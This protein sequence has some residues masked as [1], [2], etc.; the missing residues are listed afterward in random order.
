MQASEVAACHWVPLA[1]LLDPAARSRQPV[2]VSTRLAR[3]HHPALRFLLRHSLGPMLFDAVRLEPIE[4]VY[5]EDRVPLPLLWGLTHAVL[6]DFLA[7][8]P[9]FDA[10][11]AY[12]PP[13]LA[14]PDVRVLAWLF[15]PQP[16]G[17]AAGRQMVLR[18]YVSE[19][20]EAYWPRFRWAL[21]TALAA[22]GLVGLAV[23]WHLL[24]TLR[25]HVR[26]R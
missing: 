4:S 21:R 17:P 13:S 22:R 9:P 25:R 23:L 26:R 1:N 2:D 15:A 19:Y 12:R 10:F 20:L 16:P 24:R 18:N 3:T 7:L 14:A 8:L 6:A 11:D 5:G